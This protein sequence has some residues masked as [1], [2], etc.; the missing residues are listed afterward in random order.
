MCTLVGQGR[1]IERAC[2]LMYPPMYES[3]IHPLNHKERDIEGDDVG[4]KEIE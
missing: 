4:G 3:I 1:D 2:S